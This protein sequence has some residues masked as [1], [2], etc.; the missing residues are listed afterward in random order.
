MAIQIG[1]AEGSCHSKSLRGV[2]ISSDGFIANDA[3][4]LVG[5]I[6]LSPRCLA[7]TPIGVRSRYH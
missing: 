1:H 3:K 7:A 4:L 2:G 5:D 6:K